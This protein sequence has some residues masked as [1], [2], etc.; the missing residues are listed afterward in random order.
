MKNKSKLEYVLFDKHEGVGTITLNRPEK[1]NAFAGNM[2]EEILN[3]LE[4]ACTDE[5][6]RVIIITGAG[7]AFCV[8]G[9]VNEFVAGNTKA[10]HEMAT[11]ERLTFAKIVLLINS[12]EKPVIASVNGVAA[13]GGCNL[14]LACDILIA[15]ERARFGEI[16]VK[17]GVFPDWGGIYF[18]P[19]LVGYAKSAE[20][21]FSG[22]V[23]DSHEALKI[24]M[25][26]KVVP[27]DELANET[28]K[29]AINIAKNAPL[30]IAFIKRGLKNFYKMDLD[31]AMDFEKMAV[32]ICW[33][34]EDREEGFKS[35]LEKRDPHFKG[36]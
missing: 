33:N 13:G 14:A 8:G 16:F 31:Q 19:R 21:L 4:L 18:L 10:L 7:K 12:V 30:P 24:G 3:V 9:D 1:N 22:E 5:E 28:K 35:F 34:S 32:D 17:R 26:N 20:L 36:R 11:N 23:I 6:V 15:S 29:L 2:R 25:V 27:H